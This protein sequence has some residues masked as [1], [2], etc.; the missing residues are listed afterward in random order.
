MNLH[1]ST[2]RNTVIK[3]AYKTIHEDLEPGDAFMSDD[4]APLVRDYRATLDS[5]KALVAYKGKMGA[6]H[7]PGFFLIDGS[8]AS[9]SALL[10]PDFIASHVSYC[11]SLDDL[12]TL[13]LADRKVA[14]Y[15]LDSPLRV[16][17]RYVLL[18]AMGLQLIGTAHSPVSEGPN[19]TAARETLFDSTYSVDGRPVKWSDA[20]TAF[21]RPLQDTAFSLFLLGGL[22]RTHRPFNLDAYKEYILLEH[23]G[24]SVLVAAEYFGHWTWAYYTSQRGGR[25]T[26]GRASRNGD[27]FRYLN[28]RLTQTV[29]AARPACSEVMPEAVNGLKHWDGEVSM[30]SLCELDRNRPMLHYVRFGQ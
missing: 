13:G 20:P 24:D 11:T 26:T 12:I 1:S 21:R 3:S 18:G 4:V 5:S 8:D 25:L 19:I 17:F 15:L 10:E 6:S 7:E 23:A 30:P 16:G 27:N 28:P 29:R 9:P 22:A 2:T 14:H